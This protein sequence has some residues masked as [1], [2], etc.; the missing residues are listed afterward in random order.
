MA[1]N[2]VVTQFQHADRLLPTLGVLPRC[3]KCSC[4]RT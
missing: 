4:T 2:L 3:W 1:G